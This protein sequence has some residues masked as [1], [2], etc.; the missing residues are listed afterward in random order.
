[1]ADERPEAIEPDPAGNG[2][3][4]PAAGEAAGEGGGEGGEGSKKVAIPE[5]EYNAIRG[6]REEAKA[7]KEENARLK[8]EAEARRNPP[9]DHASEADKTRASIDTRRKYIARLEEAEKAGNEDAGALLAVHR[10][11]LEAEQRTLY[12]LQMADIPA[13]ERDEVKAFMQERGVAMPAVARQLMRG[14]KYETLEQENARLKSELDAAKKGKP[15]AAAVEDTRIVGSPGGSRAPA[16]K[17]GEPIALA[18]YHKRMRDDPAKTIADRKAGVFT[19][20]VD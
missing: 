10:D 1:M 18:E 11:M 14:T 2:G 5:H 7:L 15:A 8:A 4:S 20:K 19:I 13:S 9:T 3:G 16:A 12:R 17:K 6:A